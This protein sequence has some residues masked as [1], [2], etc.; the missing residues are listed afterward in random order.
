[1]Q[2]TQREQKKF[3]PE[4]LVLVDTHEMSDHERWEPGVFVEKLPDGRNLV[5]LMDGERK[6]T[7]A[8]PDKCVRH[9]K[10]AYSLKVKYEVYVDSFRGSDVLTYDG[11]SKDKALKSAEDWALKLGGL[12]DDDVAVDHVVVGGYR[13]AHYA[14][15]K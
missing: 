5:E 11:Y 10:D 2:E 9:A 14:P 4:E 15:K 7:L 12:S 1:M 8:Y 13:L 6:V 3:A